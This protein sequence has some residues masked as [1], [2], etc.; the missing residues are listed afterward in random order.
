MSDD[1]E[2]GYGKPPKKHRFQ[3]GKSGNT[4]GRPKGTKNLKT[5]LMEELGEPVQLREGG[6]RIKLTKQRAMVKSLVARAIKGNDRAATKLIDLYLKVVGIED[7][8]SDADLA[9]SPD[10]QA[11][12]KTLEDRI[13]MKVSNRSDVAD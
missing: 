8:A 3:K 5:D 9:L 6:K 2:V 7:A 12:L 11:I 13:L 1:Y 10:E 4:T